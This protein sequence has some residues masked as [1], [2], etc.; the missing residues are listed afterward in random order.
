MT[1][2]ARGCW[3]IQSSDQMRCACGNIWDTNDPE[4][5]AC[6]EVARA[7][8][9][10]KRSPSPRRSADAP[11]AVVTDAQAVAMGRTYD[12]VMMEQRAR[13]YEVRQLAAVRAAL[14]TIKL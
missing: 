1:G 5:P 3:A 2:R 12:R 10:V 13:P 7:K 8:P 6:K 4:P 11:V 9:P 14:R